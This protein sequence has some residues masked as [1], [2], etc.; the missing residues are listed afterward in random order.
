MVANQGT[1]RRF[2][3]RLGSKQGDGSI[4]ST[5]NDVSS[6]S[7]PKED[8]SLLR[9]GAT[10][11]FHRKAGHLE[12]E[13]TSHAST[14]S[15][16][17]TTEHKHKLRHRLMCCKQKESFQDVP[18]SLHYTSLN[19]RNGR[20]AT[21]SVYHKVG[22]NLGKPLNARKSNS[23]RAYD[24]APVVSIW[25]EEQNKQKPQSTAEFSSNVQFFTPNAEHAQ[26]QS[27]KFVSKTRV[28]YSTETR[29]HTLVQ[30]SK[31][32][33]VSPK[34]AKDSPKADG[35]SSPILMIR[36]TP[37]EIS[38]GPSPGSPVF[39]LTP[40]HPTMA[41]E[42][43]ATIQN[44]RPCVM[45]LDPVF[46]AFSDPT[47]KKTLLLNNLF[48]R[49]RGGLLGDDISPAGT[50]NST[51]DTDSSC[52]MDLQARIVSV[53]D[54]SS[55]TPSSVVFAERDAQLDK[56]GFPI[57]I[58]SAQKEVSTTLKN[59]ENLLD[60]LLD[61]AFENVF[62]ASLARSSPKV[63]SDLLFKH[64]STFH[65][66]ILGNVGSTAEGTSKMSDETWS[67]P[68]ED[69]HNDEISIIQQP[70]E[71]ELFGI[72]WEPAW[73]VSSGDSYDSFGC[74]FSSDYSFDLGLDELEDQEP[75][76]YPRGRSPYPRRRVRATPPQD[77]SFMDWL[78]REDVMRHMFTCIEL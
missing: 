71:G 51:I 2:E 65:V 56:D 9:V 5:I 36:R 6:P 63:P 13:E 48:R 17:I 39:T 40:T 30:E 58:D 29:K 68:E 46:P 69:K 34:G 31:Q 59:D 72:L 45:D 4:I 77:Q 74:D 21:S 50:T 12:A 60:K 28:P 70:Q 19:S 64:S 43:T 62:D 27:P 15:S 7:H 37:S 8:S 23:I 24:T 52:S 22:G 18:V 61:Q 3:R 66:G 42:D 33:L 14:T 75:S 73:S 78:E 38:S 1:R 41:R 55:P 32:K 26:R 53:F 11:R 16:T 35:E 25:N 67:N 10:T 76:N 44:R 49:K 20:N 54:D 47:L 57:D